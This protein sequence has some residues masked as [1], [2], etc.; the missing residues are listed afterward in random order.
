MDPD[1]HPFTTD[2]IG[3]VMAHGEPTD[4]PPG[5]CC[6]PTAPAPRR[7]GRPCDAGPAPSGGLGPGGTMGSMAWE[8][9]RGKWEIPMGKMGKMPEIHG[10]FIVHGKIPEF[11]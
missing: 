2:P 3:G 5:S 10:M 1:S 7:A 4:V 6:A 8:N 9:S 11:F